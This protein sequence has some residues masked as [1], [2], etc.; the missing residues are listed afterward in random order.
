LSVNNYGNIVL[1]LCKSLEL[2]IANGRLGKD[3]GT[4]A[5]TCKNSTV[6][7]YCILSPVLFS[8]VTDFEILPF[9]NMISDV[10]NA[11]HVEIVCK[12]TGT[13]EYVES[14]EP[15]VLIKPV[16]DNNSYQSFND[17]LN[18]ETIVNLNVKLDIV[19]VTT[20][21]K[22]TINNL[23]E[24]CNDII[25]QAASASGMLKEKKLS[26]N[27]CTRNN[28]K[29][30]VK[31]P[32]FNHECY[33][34]RKDYHK[35][36]NYNWRVKTADSKNNLI[37]CSKAYKKVLNFQYN[38]YRKNFIKKL[39]NL[40]HNDPKSYWSLINRSSNCNTKQN[41]LDI[42]SLECFHDHFKKL[43]NVQDGTEGDFTENIDRNVITNLNTQLNTT[44]TEKEI[45][46]AIKL[47][48]NNK[49]C[50]TDF[51]LNEFLKNSCQKMLPIFVKLFNIVFESGIIPDLWSVGI[52]CPIYKNKGDAA[53]PD[54]YR[55]IT[56]LSCYGKLFTAVLNNRLNC[57]LA[58]MNVLCEEKTGFRKKYGTYNV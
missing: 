25:I 49:S 8:Y 20:V 36:K 31:K 33:E 2:L 46:K 24:E 6:I 43:S 41:V 45:V 28:I 19:D 15:S 26:K 16:W 7:D 48:K 40:S 34:K 32:R 22:N 14:E 4:G 42:V 12:L 11:L 30:K 38:E 55:G 17:S 54:N 58:D 3:Q 18:L 56:I 52:I 39:R 35:A 50:G 57:Y 23:I 21:N 1:Q 27:N 37:R 13:N 5:L 51:I 44:I 29:C 47:L 10:H 9:D 53:N